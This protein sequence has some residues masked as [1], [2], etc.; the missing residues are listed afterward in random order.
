MFNYK[1]LSKAAVP[2]AFGDENDS[3]YDLHITELKYMYTTKFGAEVYKA[4]TDVAVEPS[5]LKAFDLN[6]RSSLAD[7][8][9]MF[10][11]G[12]GIIDNP[13]RGNI[14]ANMMRLTDE[15]LPKLPWRALQLVMR[16]KPSKVQPVQ[17]ETLN[18]T[19]RGEG[20]FGSTDKQ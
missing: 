3:G 15:P 18:N 2:P 1:L 17:V 14:M 12:T 4:I 11:Q 6:G 5:D 13:Y 7:K 16:D 9:W 20:G 10:M 8:G 19:S